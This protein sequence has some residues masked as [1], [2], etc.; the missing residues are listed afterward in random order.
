MKSF[1]II[2][3]VKW[4]AEMLWFFIFDFTCLLSWSPH[5]RMSIGLTYRIS[6]RR[7]IQPKS[8]QGD[9][10]FEL[11]NIDPNPNLSILWLTRR[12]DKFLNIFYMYS[13][14]NYLWQVYEFFSTNIIYKYIYNLYNKINENK[15][16]NEYLP[17]QQFDM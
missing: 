2:T 5:V 15:M 6:S 8:I 7:V 14:I 11:K 12:A 4:R 9:I 10:F 16:I 3:F 1:A 17:C 13:L